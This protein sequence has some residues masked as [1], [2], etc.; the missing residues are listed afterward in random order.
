MWLDPE[1]R[2]SPDG[3]RLVELL[4]VQ[5]VVKKKIWLLETAR[6]VQGADIADRPDT[7]RSALK[8]RMRS[9]YNVINL[10][11]YGVHVPFDD[12]QEGRATDLS[13]FRQA[14]A[15]GEAPDFS[16][17]FAI[18]HSTRVPDSAYQAV[19]YRGLWF[20]IDDRDFESKASFNA[21]YDLWQL[22]IKA[23]GEQSRPVTTIQVN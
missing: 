2:D 6:V 20:Y 9:L 4:N 19:R 16:E 18:R 14:V 10:Y 23:P 13:S 8:L 12:E 11:S 1:V 7:P 15:S 5:P 3:R 21:L 17:V 22:S